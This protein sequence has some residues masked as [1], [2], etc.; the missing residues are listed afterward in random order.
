MALLSPFSKVGGD[1]DAT[2]TILSEQLTRYSADGADVVAL[3]V[4]VESG[5][6]LERV[7]FALCVIIYPLNSMC[8][9]E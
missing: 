1:S 3:D 9:G 2:T 6:D 7:S 8:G 5:R 4:D